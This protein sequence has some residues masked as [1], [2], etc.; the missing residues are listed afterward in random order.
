M[1]EEGGLW[2]TPWLWLLLFAFYGLPLILGLGVGSILEPLFVNFRNI[3]LTILVIQGAYSFVAY[4][5]HSR[6]AE[7]WERHKAKVENKAAYLKSLSHQFED[8]DAD[9][10]IEAI[11]FNALLD[12]E[13]Y[14]EGDY[15]IKL[16]LSQGNNML[17]G[18]F[19]STLIKLEKGGARLVAAQ[20]KVDPRPYEG[21]FARGALDANL[22]VQRYFT[23]D[24]EGKRVLTICRF[25]PF[26]RATSFSGEDPILRD[27]TLNLQTFRNADR[28]ELLPLNLNR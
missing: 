22:H 14:P 2:P 25:A 4:Q 21:Y 18:N 5:M 1:Y 16:S 12:F 23:L 10:V 20:F 6:Y 7:N 11:V 3:Y 26:Y 8:Q 15:R 13:S 19:N 17:P 9:G 27:E 28:V 24:K